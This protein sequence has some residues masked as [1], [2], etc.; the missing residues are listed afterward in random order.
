MIKPD[1]LKKAIDS[2]NEVL[3]YFMI[4]GIGASNWFLEHEMSHGR[5]KSTPEIEK[6]LVE[7]SKQQIQIIKE[8]VKLGFNGLLDEN[9]RP[10][11]EYW[12]W[13]KW[14]SKWHK[15]MPDEEWNKVNAML[16]D[17]MTPEQISYCRP[18]GTWKI[19]DDYQI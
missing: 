16:S 3:M 6:D 19:E 11:K 18:P 7:S 9:D 13:Y 15:E 1:A 8:L 4:D 10:T 14:W 2:S 17:N 12:A 5:I